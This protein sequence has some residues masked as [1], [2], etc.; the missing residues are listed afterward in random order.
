MARCRFRPGPVCPYESPF[1]FIVAIEGLGIPLI[2]VRNDRPLLPQ[3]A[4]VL[5]F[6]TLLE[7]DHVAGN[8]YTNG[9]KIMNVKKTSVSTFETNPDAALFFGATGVTNLKFLVIIA[10]PP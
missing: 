6:A 2:S 8:G 7:V 4:C 10:N 5:L 3:S 9:L 1:R